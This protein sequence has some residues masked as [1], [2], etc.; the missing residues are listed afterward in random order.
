[1]YVNPHAENPIECTYIFPLSS[2]SVL[3]TFKATIDDR[4]ILTK[5]VDRMVAKEKY[6]DA[7][8]QGSAAVMATRKTNKDESLT[9][10]LGNIQPGSEA[11]ISFTVVS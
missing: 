7:M 3:A 2:T 10:R 9:V 1:M 8:A 11:K 5:V 4:E 6:E